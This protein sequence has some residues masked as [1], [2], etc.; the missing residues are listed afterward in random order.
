MHIH[1]HPGPSILCEHANAE[2]AEHAE[3]RCNWSNCSRS[4]QHSLQGLPSP[5]HQVPGP[6]KQRQQKL[7]CFLTWFGGSN[8]LWTMIHTERFSSRGACSCAPGKQMQ[9][10]TRVIL[11]SSWCRFGGGVLSSKP[12]P[13]ICFK[14]QLPYVCDPDNPVQRRIPRGNWTSGICSLRY[15]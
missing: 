14:C 8:D 10:S 9:L 2:H 1:I 11:E 13:H 6:G 7:R 4:N 12:L 5:W 15:S 3:H